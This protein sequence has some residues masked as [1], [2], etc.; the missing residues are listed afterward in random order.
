[1]NR[2]HLTETMISNLPPA[3]AGKITEYYDQ[4]QDRLVL[5]VTDQGG[6]TFVL[7]ARF[8][9]GTAPTRRKI[10]NAGKLKLDS[11]R[12]EARRWLDLIEQGIDP[13]DEKR[14]KQ[15]EKEE[16]KINAF[17]AVLNDYVKRHV[18]GVAAYAAAMPA[19][20]ALRLTDK[21]KKLTPLQP[22]QN[23][24]HSARP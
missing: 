11:A 10:G 5:R 3:P 17:D 2:V 24:R 6:K 23:H 20:E 13:R 21:G 14:R 12:K 1:M 8:P 22:R 9:G 19:I 4:K 16:Q 18:V 15:R 7:Y